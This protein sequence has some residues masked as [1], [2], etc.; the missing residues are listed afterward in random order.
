[1]KSA[2]SAR[3][4]AD[5]VAGPHARGAASSPSG[6]AAGFAAQSGGSAGAAAAGHAA[7][8]SETAAAD[9]SLSELL[10]DPVL[11][12]FFEQGFSAEAY[13]RGIILQVRLL[14]S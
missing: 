7:G 8:R 11:A 14:S 5:G 10:T 6:G 1:M 3:V 2:A 12:P 4:G 9:D 13:V